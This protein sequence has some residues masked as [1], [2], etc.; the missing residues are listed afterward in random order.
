MIAPIPP[1]VHHTLDDEVPPGPTDEG[2]LAEVGSFL[3]GPPFLL[4]GGTT[5]PPLLG[6]DRGGGGATHVRP[7]GPTHE[8]CPGGMELLAKHG[9]RSG[10]PCAPDGGI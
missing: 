4:G 8:V 1:I 9:V 2:L 3:L 5:T 6:K 7:S 10:V